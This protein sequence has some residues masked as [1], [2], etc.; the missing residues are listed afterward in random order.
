M[1][2]LNVMIEL[3]PSLLAK[4][5]D[6]VQ[7][8]VF[9]SRKDA[10]EAAVREKI[11]RLES[12]RQFLDECQKLNPAEEQSMAEEWLDGELESWTAF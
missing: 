10:V 2:T 1:S 5:D 7:A 12:Q 9:R 3:E 4:V 11:Q 6:F 8:H